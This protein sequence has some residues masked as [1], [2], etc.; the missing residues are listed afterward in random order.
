MKKK[1]AQKLILESFQSSKFKWRT[2]RGIS[3]E[4]GLPIQQVTDFLEASPSIVRSKKA[5][6]QGQAL[7]SVKSGLSSEGR[8]IKGLVLT[9]LD[10]AGKLVSD[11]VRRA[12]TEV[13]VETF[14]FD[15]LSPGVSLVNAIS[16]AIKASDFIVVDLTRNHPNVLYE[17]G[18]AHALRKSTILLMSSDSNSSIP[19]ALAGFQYLVYDPQNLSLLN[20]HVKR[21]AEPFIGRAED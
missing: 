17:L 19:S 9:P 16:D 7:Y 5:N 11:T 21:A 14:R 13:G 3:K 2:A 10:T 8:N 15:Q 18:F 20:D 1:D 6:K 4:I 12:L